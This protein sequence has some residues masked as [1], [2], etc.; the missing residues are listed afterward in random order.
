MHV[1]VAV[2]S[3]YGSTRGIAEAIAGKLRARGHAVDVRSAGDVPDSA[4]YDA[5]LLGSAIYNQAWL[6]EAAEFVRRNRAA[7]ASRPVWLFSVGA[8]SSVQG[9]PLGALAKHEPKEIG[10]LLEASHPRDYHVFAGAVD[11]NRLSFVGRLFFK[12]LKGRYG[13]YRNW[14]EV[15][16]RAEN[17]ARQLAGSEAVPAARADSSRLHTVNCCQRQY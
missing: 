5:V 8:I 6:S 14:Q 13:D 17:S 16:A 3:R 7:L 1:L 9:W 15:D 11:R 12:V 4:V 10:D 2:A